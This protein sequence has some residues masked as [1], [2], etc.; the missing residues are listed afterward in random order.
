MM[1]LHAASM[2]HV[3]AGTFDH[4]ERL[5]RAKQF[6]LRLRRK[7]LVQ[8]PVRFRPRD[9]HSRP[10]LFL[11]PP[12]DVLRINPRQNVQ[13]MTLTHV[14][15]EFENARFVGCPGH[16]EDAIEMSLSVSEQR[17]GKHGD[18]QCPILTRVVRPDCHATKIDAVLD[19]VSLIDPRWRPPCSEVDVRAVRLNDSALFSLDRRNVLFEFHQ[20]RTSSR[21][22]QRLDPSN[23][24]FKS[25]VGRFQIPSHQNGRNAEPSGDIIE[26]LHLTIF[27]QQRRQRHIDAQ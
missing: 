23:R 8:R 11:V 15:G 3:D 21:C 12:G 2:P 22:W 5:G 27:G 24:G 16:I 26:P 13:G 4:R 18:A 20:D 6:L 25:N 9:R 1:Q 19:R 14:C 10:L 17:A 7:A